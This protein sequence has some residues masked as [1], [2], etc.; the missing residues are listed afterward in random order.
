MRLRS[1]TGL[2][3]SRM[4]PK[5]SAAR[6]KARPCGSLAPLAAL[7]FNGNKIVTT[8]GGGAILTS[9][10]DLARR[11]RHLTTTAKLPHRWAFLHDEVAWNFRLPN[12]NAALGLAQ[13]ERLDR[14][15]L[16]SASFESAMRQLLP[17]CR[18][19][20]VRGGA[21]VAEQLLAGRAHARCSTCRPVGADLAGD[22][23]CGLMTRP[24]WTP[25]HLLPM[26]AEHPRAPLAGDR[27]LGAAHHQ[28]ALEPIPGR[29]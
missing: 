11:L 25:M 12:L 2:P 20:G 8:G 15:S 26:Y 23:R 5:R 17:V 22:Q 27:R 3:S 13:L 14:S 10:A 29:T 6:Y 18:R 19:A 24:V 21:V 7:S 16:P 9:D 1:A 28:P 4:R